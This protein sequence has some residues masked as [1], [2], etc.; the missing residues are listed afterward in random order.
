MSRKKPRRPVARKKP[1]PTDPLQ[2]RKRSG[3]R[4]PGRPPAVKLPQV[5]RKAKISA[6]DDPLE[7]EADRVADHVVAGQSAPQISSVHGGAMQPQRIQRETA[8]SD[9]SEQSE[10]EETI[11][12]QA[13]EEEEVQALPLQR[14]ESEEE[15]T[16]Q[17]QTEEEEEPVQTLAGQEEEEEA[18]Q[19]QSEEEEEELQ[20][21]FIQRDVAETAEEPEADA[22]ESASRGSE[23]ADNEATALEAPDAGAV[24]QEDEQEGDSEQ[25]VEEDEALG[26]KL[27]EEDGVFQ[28]KAASEEDTEEQP[29]QAKGAPRSSS[30]TDAVDTALGR[31]RSGDKLDPQLRSRMESSTGYDLSH[32]RIHNDS[33]AHDAARDINARAFTQGR[34]I[35]L[36]RGESQS[37]TRLMAHELTHVVQQSKAP[38]AA[39]VQRDATSPKVFENRNKGKIDLDA[40]T[41]VIPS[42]KVPTA[43]LP[44]MPNKSNLEWNKE[45]RDTAQE[46]KWNAGVRDAV[47]GKLE[48]KLKDAPDIKVN[49]KRTFYL[50][51]GSGNYL[52][53]TAGKIKDRARR[54]TWNKSKEVHSFDIDH[55]QEDQL[56]GPDEFNNMWLWDSSAN[57]SSGSVLKTHISDKITE[58]LDLSKTDPKGLGSKTPPMSKVKRSYTVTF[59]RARGGLALGSGDPGVFWSRQDILTGK[60]I[61]KLKLLKKRS[62]IDKVRGKPTE[63]SIFTASH[64]GQLF[65]IKPWESGKTAASGEFKFY[66]SFTATRIDMNAGTVSGKVMENNKWFK[67]KRIT[68]DLKEQEGVAY[69]GYVEGGRLKSQ[70]GKL[71]FEGLSPVTITEAS[72]VP[73]PGIMAR[74]KLN[75]SVPLISKADVDIEIL[76]NDVNLAKTLAAPDFEFPKPLTVSDASVT[77]RAGTGGLAAN[78]KAAFEL[79]GVGQGEI[80]A[81]ASTEKGFEAEGKFSF[82]SELFEP[83]D[84]KVWYKEQK[85]GGEG[86]LGIKEGKIKGIKSA[87]L[88]VAVDDQKWEATGTVEPKVPGVKEGS[89][90]VKFDP[91][92][93]MEIAGR[94][95]FSGDIPRVKGGHLQATVMKGQEGY[96]V[97]GTGS[98]ELDIPG[99]A[100]SVSVEYDDGLFKAEA[101]VGYDRGIASG[102]LTV[103]VTNMPVGDDGQP[104]GATGDDLS[105]YGDGRVTIK[106]TPWLQGTAG[107][108]LDPTGK[109]QVVG[110]VAIPDTVEVFPQKKIEKELLSVG[111]DIPIVG[112]AVAGQRIG[113]FLN[114]SGSVSAKAS[115]GPGE[116]RE[117]QVEITY[118]PE[119]ESSAQITGSAR[120][121]VPAEAGL[122]LA[123][124][125]ALGAGIPIVSAKAG[126]EIGGELGVK[127]EAA[128]AAQV[129]W[130][131]QTGINLDAE[132]SLI[133]QPKFTF[134]V[135]GFVEVTADLLL[136][137]IDL[138]S[139]RWQLAAFEYGSNMQVGAKLPV[140]VENG[141]F[142]DISVDDIEFITPDISP[143]DVAK[144]L[145]KQIA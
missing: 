109:M 145:I 142:K 43:K 70:L 143:I 86:N 90:S 83:A 134:D 24:K 49:G 89:L 77:L 21:K 75:P 93:G 3:V 121:V 2:R 115:I 9:S 97:K 101:K 19:A 128:A 78:G 136:T 94:L 79:E 69:G 112:V 119:D 113:I 23:G 72:L 139:K 26:Q 126:L 17:A 144:N 124:S 123:I 87:S 64:G 63:L 130:T 88:K 46:S 18:V 67:R 29:V 28:A 65:K 14:E 37:N 71:G 92:G 13:Q 82:D 116:L 4:S 54:P 56:S 114:I 40:K 47:F 103:G 57:R 20:A 1:R 85:F 127:G 38:A 51:A 102:S 12:R 137:E 11:A 107:I 91:Q 117:A 68:L 141:K 111:V 74:G 129:E 125:G 15:E 59:K 96:K 30:N 32:V 53:G 34:D 16:V 132:V 5:R 22:E 106:F 98:A 105:V 33:A 122:R 25:S 52:V 6:K 73:G 45:E 44:H 104:A 118:D 62:E 135:T 108:K 7:K 140:K 99:V 120:F 138:Y 8:A 35:W 31:R 10:E 58:L 27:P 66:D 60:H 42:V 39:P 133:A 55:I 84:I 41:I 81:S 95:E 80:N 61:N 48:N 110:K 36:G 76:G 50:E 100:S 131:P